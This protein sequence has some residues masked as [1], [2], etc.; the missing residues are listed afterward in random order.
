MRSTMGQP[1]QDIST[2][3]LNK[4]VSRDVQL[5]LRKYKMDAQGNR[6]T[7]SRGR[8]ASPTVRFNDRG[9]QGV[10]LADN[11]AVRTILKE[12]DG[13]IN[14]K[15]SLLKMLVIKFDEADR[16]MSACRQAVDHGDN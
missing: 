8:E 3:V 4:V 12:L 9:N 14:D 5:E 6:K 2:T 11:K 15:V 10:D 16:K 1:L 7:R 13:G